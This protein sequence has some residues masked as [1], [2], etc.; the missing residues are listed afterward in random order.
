MASNTVGSSKKFIGTTF[1]AGRAYDTKSNSKIPRRGR[2]LKNSESSVVEKPLTRSLRKQD[3]LP[4]WDV[5]PRPDF[6]LEE[7]VWA[8]LIAAKASAIRRCMTFVSSS[9]Q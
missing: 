4:C 3:Q 8:V 9:T 5:S 7:L 2:L 6:F 1:R